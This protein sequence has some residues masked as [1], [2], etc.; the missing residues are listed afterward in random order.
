MKDI[1]PDFENWF[2]AFKK[3][4]WLVQVD[5]HMRIISIHGH[6]NRKDIKVKEGCRI[7]SVRKY[8]N[9]FLTDE[10]LKIIKTRKYGRKQ[11]N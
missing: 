1:K 2:A 3:G 4:C 9:E 5:E 7:V 11:D 8:F 6:R 10:E